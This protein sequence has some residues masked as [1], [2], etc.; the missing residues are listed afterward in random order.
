MKGT[1]YRGTDHGRA[2]CDDGNLSL[3]SFHAGP[4]SKGGLS[5]VKANTGVKA[6][7]R[8]LHSRPLRET[9]PTRSDFLLGKLDQRVAQAQ[10]FRPG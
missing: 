1:D 6:G 10:E 7:T 9:T 2:T 3:Q 5:Q 4:P 8:G